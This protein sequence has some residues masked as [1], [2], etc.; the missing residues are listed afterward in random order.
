MVNN[1]KK[2]DGEL[3]FVE[4]KEPAEV[5]R[6][7]L[8]SLR[9]ILE[10]LKEFEKFKHIRH[11]KSEKIQK[12]RGLVRGTNKMMGRLRVSLPQTSLRG[13]VVKQVQRP[14]KAVHKPKAPK[15]HTELERLEAEL[16]SIESKL[17]SFT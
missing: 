4:I 6:N 14:K 12:L 2:Q 3:F 17:K 1:P 15:K 11:E 16:G 9:N 8:E 7:I 10:M 5:R 13:V